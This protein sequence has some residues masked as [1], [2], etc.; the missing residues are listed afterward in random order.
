MT[1]QSCAYQMDI[2]SLLSPQETTF[3]PLR[4]PHSSVNSTLGAPRPNSN[5]TSPPYRPNA[6][7]EPSLPYNGFTYSQAATSSPTLAS[8]SSAVRGHVSNTPPVDAGRLERRSS[9]TGMDTLADLASMQH[10]RQTVRDTGGRFSSKE[11]HGNKSPSLNARASAHAQSL[12]PATGTGTKKHATTD[13]R[14]DTYL[15]SIYAT[16]ALSEGEVQIIAEL[17]EYLRSNPHAFDSHVRLVKLLHKGLKS[18]LQSNAGKSTTPHGYDLLPHLKRARETMSASFA[19]G[20]ELW[21]EWIEDEKILTRSID[22]VLGVIEL[23]QKAVEQEQGSCRLWFLY[24]EWMLTTFRIA[25]PHEPVLQGLDLPSFTTPDLSKEDLM[26]AQATIN[27]Q[28]VLEIWSQGVQATMWRM[29]DSNLLWDQCTE[30]VVQQFALSPGTQSFEQVRSHYL[31]RLVI[32]HATWDQT[33]QSFSTFISSY[34]NVNYEDTMVHGTQLGVAAKHRY[35]M[36]DPW[37]TELGQAQQQGDRDVE[38]RCFMNYIDWELAQ[39][40]PKKLFDFDLT[41]AL[42]QRAIL[43]FPTDT[44]LWESL[45][46]L[47]ND[48]FSSR[49]KQKAS[50][51]SVLDR[52]TQHCPWSGSLW[53]QYLVA[54]ERESQPFSV[55]EQIKHKATSTSTLDAGGLEEVIKVH[56]TWGGVLRRRAFWQGATEE[57]LDVAEVGIRSA[58][59]DMDNLGRS[60]YGDAYPGDPAYRLER[61]YI[62]YLT[63]RHNWSAARETWKS[64][65]PRLGENYEF[66]LR[67]YLWEM[68]TYSKLTY[69]G[70]QPDIRVPKPTEATKVLRQALKRPKLDWPERI[71]EI[72]RTHCE[73]FEDAHEL[74]L[75]SVLIWKTTKAIK[76]RREMEQN[77]AHGVGG[78]KYVAQPEVADGNAGGMVTAKRKR[79]DGK[80]SSETPVKKSKPDLH[81]SVE[82]EMTE[83]PEAVTFVPKRDRENATV[84]VR[85]LPPLIQEVKIRQYFRDVSTSYLCA[86]IY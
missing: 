30:M 65:I 82:V 25:N 50:I 52:A 38:W 48:E 8:P 72:F 16:N 47:L 33:F 9:T 46:T 35:S 85:N 26:V 31:E 40:R 84:V 58:I 61:I 81:Q 18:H 19:I 32:P 55:M 44:E 37:E 23:C 20:E 51:L 15:P 13:S 78:H 75:A 27:W 70:G 74:Q 71:L 6:A 49:S 53:S 62:R 63:Q 24:A 56:T 67:Y 22:D 43:R 10:H 14:M 64:L 11:V 68:G 36:R 21:I 4:N 54:A 3:N 28:Q 80:T 5:V 39:S 83:Q 73:D 42:H 79:D 66:W 17:D 76:K 77:S 86:C 60:T 59:E 1:A 29:N 12:S 41:F 7:S 57:D 2:N 34:D 69:Q 45:V